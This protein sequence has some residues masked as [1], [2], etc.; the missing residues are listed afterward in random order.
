MYWLHENFQT[1]PEALQAADGMPRLAAIQRCEQLRQN[2]RP[3]RV[4]YAMRSAL[5]GPPGRVDG[6]LHLIAHEL[7]I[8]LQERPAPSDDYLVAPYCIVA[9]DI[10]VQGVAL[11][12]R[13]AKSSSEMVE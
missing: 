1:S 8:R 7:G 4:C 6:R 12:V 13:Y 3:L 9:P 10:T 11:W 5:S 2:Y